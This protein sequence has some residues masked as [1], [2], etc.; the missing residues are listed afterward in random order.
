MPCSVSIQCHRCIQLCQAPMQPPCRYQKGPVSHHQWRGEERYHPG[1]A[2]CGPSLDRSPRAGTLAAA[3]RSGTGR[4]RPRKTGR[5]RR[6]RR[7]GAGRRTSRPPPRETPEHAWFATTV[8]AGTLAATPTPRLPP[9]HADRPPVQWL[10]G[11][12]S[13][14]RRSHVFQNSRRIPGG[15]AGVAL[16]A[17]QQ[18]SSHRALHPRLQRARWG[19]TALVMLRGLDLPRGADARKM[20]EL[21]YR[22]LCDTAFIEGLRHAWSQSAKNEV[23]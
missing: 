13:R 12:R 5:A 14:S 16:C 7:A 8:A 15:G 11:R 17:A 20:L 22:C 1:R 3:C 4:S 6:S 19:P 18:T 2:K 10:Q 21:G 23:W 9:S